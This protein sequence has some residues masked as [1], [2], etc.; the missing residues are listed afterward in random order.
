MSDDDSRLTRTTQVPSWMVQLAVW[1]IG[2]LGAG[3]CLTVGGLVVWAFSIE[4]RVSTLETS[5]TVVVNSITAIGA[6]ID[7]QTDAIQQLQRDM[8][9]VKSRDN[10]P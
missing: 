5:S 1:T 9:V 10:R 3:A 8:D 6:K 4:K 2:S 7:R